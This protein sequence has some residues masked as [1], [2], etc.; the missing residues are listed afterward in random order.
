MIYCVVIIII[1]LRKNKQTK[2]QYFVFYNQKMQ[3][4]NFFPLFSAKNR[5][6][7]KQ[8][9]QIISNKLLLF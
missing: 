7:K 1:K 5:T 4:W 9:N 3:D 6:N 8:G 2:V